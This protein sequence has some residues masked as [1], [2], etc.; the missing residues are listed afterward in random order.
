MKKES[1]QQEQQMEH[2]SHSLKSLNII[3]H[4]V[5]LWDLERIRSF[6]Y[7][8]GM[9][10]FALVLCV[11]SG[12]VGWLEWWWLGVFIAPTTILVIGCVLCRRAHR[13]LHCSL[14]CACHVSRSL[15]FW[16]VDRWLRLSLWCTRQSGV[17]WRRRMSLTFW[18]SEPVVVAWQSTVGEDDHWPWAHRTVQW[19]LAE[20]HCVFP[21]AASS[22]DAPA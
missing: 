8:F 15:R 9:Y 21:R 19:F 4:L 1:K 18:R 6:E 13:T 3:N 16:A 10:S 22:L 5:W 11:E 7:V 17:T 2:K 12:K 20:E 14:S